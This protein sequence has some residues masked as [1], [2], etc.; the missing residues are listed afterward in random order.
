[1]VD[2]PSV[3]AVFLAGLLTILTP[4]CLPMLPPLLAGGVGHRLRPL[5]IVTGSVVSF[6]AAGVATGAVAG[7]G[8]D[9]FRLPFTVL[10]VG[11]GVV[12]LDDG[13]NAAY[14]RRASRLAGWATDLSSGLERDAHPVASGVALGL[15]LGVIWLPCVGP[16]L[17]AVLAAVGQTG[18]LVRSG[19]LLFVYGWGFGVP[20]LAVAYGGNRTVQWFESRLL[21]GD[22]P[23]VLRRVTGAVLVG[24]GVSLLFELDKLAM[25]FANG[26]V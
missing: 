9:T 3:T 12:L 15:L 13:I 5:G 8:P 2:L 23:A 6:T 25:T 16:V 17:G 26:T 20:L 1:M 4:C 11:F 22:R 14:E 18:D 19:T 7:L 10:V 24:T 21:A